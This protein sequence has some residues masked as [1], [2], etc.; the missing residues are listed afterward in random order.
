MPKTKKRP[1]Y[2]CRVKTY[3][4]I[5]RIGQDPDV[6]V[7][8]V[9]RKSMSLEKLAFIKESFRAIG[10]KFMTIPCNSFEVPGAEKVFRAGEDMLAEAPRAKRVDMSNVDFADFPPST[11]R[12]RP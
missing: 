10:A 6:V 11:S 9:Y 1:P 2:E 3:Q 8:I 7:S 12:R 4:A 5:D